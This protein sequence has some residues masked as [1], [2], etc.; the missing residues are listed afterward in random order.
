MHSVLGSL[1]S[2]VNPAVT[3]SIAI[4]RKFS[5]WKV[6]YYI[7]FQVLGAFLA[8]LCIYGVYVIPIRAVD[9]DQTELT[10]GI[11]CTF[12]APFLRTSTSTRLISFYNEV[13]AT[14]VLMIVI[15][16]IGDSNNTPP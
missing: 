11:F 10:A 4:F 15:L 1:Y 3:L 12:P 8:A 16:A 9:P 13:L 14:M 6:P 7:A 2:S 5:W